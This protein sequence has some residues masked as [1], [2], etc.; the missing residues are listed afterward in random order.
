MFSEVNSGECT[1]LKVFDEIN[2]FVLENE[3]TT[4]GFCFLKSLQSFRSEI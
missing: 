3:D 2:I 4:S 1:V